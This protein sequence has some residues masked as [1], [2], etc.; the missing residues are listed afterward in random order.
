MKI[1]FT[2]MI[3]SMISFI[4]KAQD[5]NVFMQRDASM[6]SNHYEFYSNGTFKH[7]YST[8]D[9]QVWYGA[10]N[11]FDNGKYRTLYF[12]EADTTM[13]EYQGWKIYYETNFQ[14][15]LIKKG[16]GFKSFEKNSNTGKPGIKLRKKVP[17][18]T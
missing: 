5:S 9:F 10:G 18:K 1:L 8:D 3:L 11:Y 4:S 7:F 13:N 17:N 6:F 12:K 16:C 15:V 2:T 14:R